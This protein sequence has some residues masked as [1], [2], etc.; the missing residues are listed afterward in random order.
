MNEQDDGL[1]SLGDVKWES[2]FRA[3]KQLLRA[4]ASEAEVTAFVNDAL[5]KAERSAQSESP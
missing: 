3:I 1:F 5:G 2:L 4:G